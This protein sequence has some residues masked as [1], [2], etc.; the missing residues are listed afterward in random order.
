MDSIITWL[1]KSEIT[2]PRFV[3]N[4]QPRHV[5]M[6]AK[7]CKLHCTMPHRFI[8]ITDETKGFSDDVEVLPTPSAAKKLAKYRTAEQNERF[9]SSYPR[10]W[11]FSS[12][13]MCLGD[14]VLNLDVDCM[15]VGDL[16]PLFDN[17]HDFVGWRPNKCWGNETRIGG[18]TW[19]LRTGTHVHV[20]E[21]FS[22]EE[23]IKARKLGWRGSDQA[24]LSYCL[25]ETCEVWPKDSGI[26]HKQDG[27]HAWAKVPSD[28]RIIHFNGT[29]DY[30][31]MDHLPW[32]REYL[33]KV[34]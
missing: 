19:L 32:I 1:W 7:A 12:E 3:R 14:R 27:S 15:V 28:A 21:N 31:D 13:A 33:K 16:K 9:P 20:F 34:G 6:L 23:A 30:W 26:Y 17:V 24:W 22:M 4:Y 10:L 5:N 8:C 2:D 18:G 25:S 11:A 29:G